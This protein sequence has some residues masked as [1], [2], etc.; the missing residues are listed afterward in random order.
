M[1]EQNNQEFPNENDTAT[2]NQMAADIRTLQSDMNF[3]K[4]ELAKRTNP[5]FLSAFSQ[6]LKDVINDLKTEIKADLDLAFAKQK[7]EIKAEIKADLDSALA[8][9]KAEIKAEIKADLDLAF[10][11]QKAELKTELKADFEATLSSSILHLKKE[12]RSD[13]EIVI[14]QLKTELREE[15]DQTLSKAL[16]LLKTELKDEL[17]NELKAELKAEFE[18]ILKAELQP[19]K[20]SIQNLDRMLN[21]FE[22]ELASF[23]LLFRSAFLDFTVL[24]DKLHTRI[25]KLED[26]WKQHIDQLGATHNL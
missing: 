3:V 4:A 25:K 23:R 24:Q 18:E 15:F 11:K 20:D 2:L 1:T 10:A 9:Q 7:V 16:S 5:E 6:I 12:L 22:E 21:N 19:I 26:D 14:S 17:K 13:F 8:K